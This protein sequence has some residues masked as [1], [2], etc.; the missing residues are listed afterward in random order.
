MRIVVTGTSGAGKTTLGRRISADFALPHIELD[1][2]N[3]QANWRDL[4]SNDPDAF[5]R[6]VAEAIGADTWVVDGNYPPVRDLVW[7]R[8]THLIWLDYER[9][10]IMGRVIRRSLA[11]AVLRT[12]LW[13]GNREQ[14]R[15][16]LHPGHPIRWA[17][18]TWER[19][20][21]ETEAR[22]ARAEFMGLV[23]FRLHRPREAAAVL[24]L[25]AERN[26]RAADHAVFALPMTPDRS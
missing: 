22:L 24:R 19:Q 14:W 6:R 9:P 18:S 4:V 12:P 20:R 7:R 5:I 21:R 1:A 3:W 16:L 23:T 2:I 15:R 13:A 11:R 26:K 10:V 25:L 17:W 8:A